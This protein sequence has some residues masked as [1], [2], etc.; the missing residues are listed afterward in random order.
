MQKLIDR[1]YPLFGVT[2]FLSLLLTIIAAVFFPRVNIKG[3]SFN[4][5]AFTTSLFF[6]SLFVVFVSKPSWSKTNAL[7]GWKKH[8]IS[9]LILLVATITSYF[10]IYLPFNSRLIIEIP[11]QY[12]NQSEPFAIKAESDTKYYIEIDSAYTK[13]GTK[14]NLIVKN[15]K[16]SDNFA[17]TVGKKRSFSDKA[18]FGTSI[19]DLPFNFPAND[20]YQLFIQFENNNSSVEK[21][22]LFKML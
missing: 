10:G 8:F 17:F 3:Y 16:W 14:I 20:T 9:I 11:S 19:V 15:E 6:I 13:T 12:L 18:G 21:I 1:I 7:H 22:R 2:L 5:P 4:V